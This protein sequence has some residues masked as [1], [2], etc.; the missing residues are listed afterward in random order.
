[1]HSNGTTATAMKTARKG[2]VP[3]ASKPKEPVEVIID[4]MDLDA[5]LDGS[6]S[7]GWFKDHATAKK[8]VRDLAKLHQSNRRFDTVP[9][10]EREPEP[11]KTYRVVV[12]VEETRDFGELEGED[13]FGHPKRKIETE[14]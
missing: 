13:C 8:V 2:K 11:T 9:E 10:P 5:G 4:L 12:A 7:L 3:G 14:I 6:R 1:M